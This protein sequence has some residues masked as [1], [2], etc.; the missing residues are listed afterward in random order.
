MTIETASQWT[1]EALYFAFWVNDNALYQEDIGE[2]I[3][4]GDYIELWLDMDLESDYEENKMS[5]DDFQIGF[6]PGNFDTVSP[7]AHIWFPSD[8]K[9]AIHDIEFISVRTPNGYF[10]ESRIPFKLILDQDKI[11]RRNLNGLKIGISISAS[12]TD[13]LIEPQKCLISS[14]IGRVWGDP[15]TFDFLKLAA[16]KPP[17]FKKVPVNRIANIE[18]IGSDIWRENL[19]ELDRDFGRAM[20]VQTPTAIVN[21]TIMEISAFGK[22]TFLTPHQNKF[23]YRGRVGSFMKSPSLAKVTTDFFGYFKRSINLIINDSKFLPEEESSH[24]YRIVY[25]R[26]LDG[27]CGFYILILGNLSSYNELTFLIRGENGSE[28]FEVGLVD[29]IDEQKES[30]VYS[31]SIYRYLPEGLSTEWQVVKIPLKHFYG[32]DLSKIWS[33]SFLFNKESEGTIWIDQI[34]LS[35]QNIAALERDRDIT[36]NQYFLLE[37]FNHSSMNYLG[38]KSGVYNKWPSICRYKKVNGHHETQ[39]GLSLELN[40]NKK[41]TGWCGYYIRLGKFGEDYF[42]MSPY[43]KISFSVKGATG[44]EQFELGL[45]DLKRDIIGDALKTGSILNYLPHGLSTEWQHVEMPI[46]DFDLLNL[47][48]MVSLVVNF[49]EVGVGKVYVDDIKFLM[50]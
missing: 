25:D 49:H 28:S 5:S 31:G 33:L 36:S 1:D 26:D 37:D 30:A 29:I 34:R 32:V 8:K 48:K 46:E 16:E 4:K 39:S 6:S 7:S 2:S 11:G 47:K 44:N 15:T 19:G 13:T 23:G 40:Y 24:C 12:D 50:N 10:I 9:V 3:W 35:N 21:H 14:S 42:D 20:P 27:F 45:V 38:G 17:E 22:E 43:K 18:D 41:A